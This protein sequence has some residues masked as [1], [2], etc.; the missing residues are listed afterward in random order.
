MTVLSAHPGGA[1]GAVPG[2]VQRLGQ[3]AIW[4]IEVPHR[5]SQRKEPSALVVC[6]ETELER[7]SYSSR[8]GHTA[9]KE[10]GWAS[11]WSNFKAPTS[12]LICITYL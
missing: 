11:T 12:P 10:Q 1:F 9:S 3:A 6:E 4:R 8:A 7:L 2:T 5:S